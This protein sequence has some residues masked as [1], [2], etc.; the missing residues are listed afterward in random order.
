MPGLELNGLQVG[1]F[2]PVAFG[3]ESKAPFVSELRCGSWLAAV[4]SACDGTATWREHTE[5]AQQQGLVSR[6][7]TGDELAGVLATL[8]SQGILRIRERPLPPD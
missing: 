2:A 3:I 8:V 6:E 7:A 1:R 4:I 5:R